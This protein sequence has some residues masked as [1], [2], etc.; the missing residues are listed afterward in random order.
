MPCSAHS[1]AISISKFWYRYQNYTLF[2]IPFSQLP[3]FIL[4][5]A[6]FHATPSCQAVT[7]SPDLPRPPAHL[8]HVSLSSIAIHLLVHFHSFPVSIRICLLNSKVIEKMSVQKQWQSPLGGYALIELELLFWMPPSWNE[9]HSRCLVTKFQRCATKR[10]NN[11][12]LPLNLRDMMTSFLAYIPL[13]WG[14]CNEHKPGFSFPAFCSAGLSLPVWFLCFTI[15]LLIPSLIPFQKSLHV[16]PAW[17][18]LTFVCFFLLTHWTWSFLLS[19]LSL[20]QASQL[21]EVA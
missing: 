4:L 16:L 11:L 7:P 14:H 3:V 15:G 10:W 8:F 19:C 12:E 21:L 1:S 20:S 6:V 18:V 13:H 5:H 9:K 2:P 17:L